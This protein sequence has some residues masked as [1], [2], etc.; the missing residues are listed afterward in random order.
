MRK[1]IVRSFELGKDGLKKID[2]NPS[3]KCFV[4]HYENEV[5]EVYMSSEELLRNN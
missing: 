3:K 1:K 2:F 4:F 5:I